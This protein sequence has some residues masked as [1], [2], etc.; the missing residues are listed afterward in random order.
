MERP[1]KPKN[2]KK[3][4]PITIEELDR[5]NNYLEVIDQDLSTIDPNFTKIKNVLKLENENQAV[6][7]KDNK[8]I[9]KNI[10]YLMNDIDPTQVTL[11]FLDKDDTIISQTREI[12][13]NM[14][15]IVGGAE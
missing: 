15:L 11:L 1:F 14:V 5:I 9:T 4:D 10:Y 6:F 13:D 3:N 7:I 12:P 2:W 8:L